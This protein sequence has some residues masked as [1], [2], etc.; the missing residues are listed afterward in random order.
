MTL[1]LDPDGRAE[2]EPDPLIGVRVVG[3]YLIEVLLGRGG[4]GSVYLARD[5]DIGR[6]AIKVLH[7]DLSARGEI[8]ARFLAEARSASAIGNPYIVRFLAKGTL[9]DGRVY[10]AM[11]Y[12]EGASLE[13]CL[14]SWGVLPARQALALLSMA[15]YAL[16]AA[17]DKGIVHRD[18]KPENLY[19]TPD[20]PGE[21][22]SLKVL[23]FGIAKIEDA[24]LAGGVV[25]RTG[26]VLG[27]PMYMSPE[28]ATGLRIDHRSDIYSMAMVAHKM[29]TGIIPQ[30]QP[31]GGGWRDPR[32]YRPDL[33]PAFAR[34][35][36]D[37][38]QF[39][40]AARPSSM[41][42]WLRMLC[43]GEADGEPIVRTYAAGFNLDIADYREKTRKH[44]A[45]S[46]SQPVIP[47]TLGEANGEAAVPVATMAPHGRTARWPLVAA[48]AGLAVA[49]I[50][51]AL[52]LTRDHAGTGGEPSEPTA[53]SRPPPVD[54]APVVEPA[55]ADAA[56]AITVASATA[57][58]AV[59]AIA[60]V[61]HDAAPATPPEPRERESSKSRESRSTRPAGTGTLHVD[62]TPWA[63]V[64]LD[65]KRLGE[66]PTN[67]KVPAGRHKLKITN[68]TK[69]ESI[70]VT[71]KPDK[72]TTVERHW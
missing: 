68:D 31:G 12:L 24:R 35:I 44:V 10:L 53:A 18:I 8:V 22:G 19:W 34:A 69:T 1:L 27:T 17:H 55:T 66:T 50:A 20:G 64:F 45:P 30:A 13:A 58:A 29:V 47:T 21:Y 48:L 37:G 4:M 3:D 9:P 5:P 38:L 42:E 6:I 41:R 26:A 62:V 63:I 59:P 49:G 16:S 7:A 46:L 72:T 67:A 23:D 60:E 52:V 40:P 56:P 57:D 36:L 11:E 43:D 39:Q 14:A 70:T 25:T 65:G 71:I 32:E 61:L 15:C 51:V 54:A 28:Q 33:S 2:G